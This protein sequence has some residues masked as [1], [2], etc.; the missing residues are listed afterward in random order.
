MSLCSQCRKLKTIS[1]CTDSL[2][3]GTVSGL[4]QPY[5][6][7]FKS[8]AT[9]KIFSYAVTSNAAG[10]ITL[11]FSA[12]FPL[13][14][15]TGYDMWVNRAGDSVDDQSDLT[16]GSVTTTCYQLSASMIW[17]MYYEEYENFTSQTLEIAV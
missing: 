11:T 17:D 15:L 14:T 4:S 9:G 12:A 1:L 16:I 6:V 5:I 8:L 2:I 13:A 7:Y 3:I 10:L